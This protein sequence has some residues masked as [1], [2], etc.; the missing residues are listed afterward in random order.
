[1]VAACASTK[2]TVAPAKSKQGGPGGEKRGEGTGDLVS[3]RVLRAAPRHRRDTQTDAGRTHST[4][5]RG[6]RPRPELQRTAQHARSH[7]MR[8][9]HETREGRAPPATRI[10]NDLT[11]VAHSN[12]DTA[13]LYAPRSC[14]QKPRRAGKG[15][16]FQQEGRAN[17]IVRTKCFFFSKRR[18]DA[19]LP[20]LSAPGGHWAEWRR[21]MERRETMQGLLV[22]AALACCMSVAVLSVDLE[23]LERGSRAPGRSSLLWDAPSA[24]DG[25]FSGKLGEFAPAP[26]RTDGGLIMAD[27][28]SVQSLTNN[29]GA[30]NLKIADTIKGLAASRALPNFAAALYKLEQSTATASKS[31]GTLTQAEDW[32]NTAT[33]QLPDPQGF[34]HRMQRMRLSSRYCRVHP[35]SCKTLAPEFP[36]LD[37]VRFASDE[38]AHNPA[39][40][41]EQSTAADLLGGET[42]SEE[43]AAQQVLH[44]RNA[45]TQSLYLGGGGN[46]A[47]GGMPWLAPYFGQHSAQSEAENQKW[48]EAFTEDEEPYKNEEDPLWCGGPSCSERSYARHEHSMGRVLPHIVHNKAAMRVGGEQNAAKICQETGCS[49]TGGRP[50]KYG[51][52]S[53]VIPAVLQAR[54]GQAATMQLLQMPHSKVGGQQLGPPVREGGAKQRSRRR[55]GMRSGRRGLALVGGDGKA[56]SK[57]AA[58]F[59]EAASPVGSTL[60]RLDALASEGTK[61]GG[62]RDGSLPSVAGVDM[63]V[64]SRESP[65]IKLAEEEAAQRTQQQRL[66]RLAKL[67]AA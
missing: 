18:S 62:V 19:A 53:V 24:V 58:L 65:A 56:Y 31:F 67:L 63:T 16:K 66:S 26:R 47:D 48:S 17:E 28:G 52:T 49:D 41:I 2:N 37:G 30:N 46:G 12:A 59:A 32:R 61:K 43:G 11:E 9:R 6:V 51:Y 20:P 13:A 33:K 57:G 8:T 29:I 60:P 10:M 45:R 3:V 34:V 40:P 36:G 23:A 39:D 64:F 7:G 27:T 54:A 44:S 50:G 15:L 22:A 42:R 35:E 25:D 5:V 55:Q 4:A 38:V 1:M 21:A 14:G